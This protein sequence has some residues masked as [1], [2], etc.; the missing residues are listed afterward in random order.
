MLKIKNLNF[1]YKNKQILNN[2]NLEITKN[3]ALIALNGAGKS[4]LFNCIT[5]NIKNNAQIYINNNDIQKMSI[6]KLAKELSYLP[7][8]IELSIKLTVFEFCL[9]SCNLNNYFAKAKQE[10][11]IKINNILKKFKLFHLRNSYFNELSGGQQQLIS[12]IALLCNDSKILIL[13]EPFAALDLANTKFLLDF[14][15]SLNKIIFFS[16]HNIK[17][18][19]YLNCDIYLLKNSQIEKL[20]KIDND[21]LNYIYE[22]DVSKLI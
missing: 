7:Q 20:N 2:I 8:N 15:T 12:I 21:I 1:S 11:I 16:T 17:H 5:N 14:F 3:S 22:C 13:D 10:D 4:T 6:K 18:A 9:F 19:L